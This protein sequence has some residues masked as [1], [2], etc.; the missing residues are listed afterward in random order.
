MRSIITTSG[1]RSACSR[2]EVSS[3]H[4]RILGYM[5]IIS[6]LSSAR[7]GGK[8]EL[9]GAEYDARPSLEGCKMFTP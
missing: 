1:G 4:V 3:T 5:P 7:E 2:P 9:T 8:F 6:V